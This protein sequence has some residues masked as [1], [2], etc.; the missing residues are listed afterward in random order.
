MT[1]TAQTDVDELKDIIEANWHHASH[2]K[3]NATLQVLERTRTENKITAKV[4]GNHGFILYP[5]KRKTKARGRL[6]LLHR[7]RRRLSSLLLS[8]AHVLNN[9][10]SF[11]AVREKVLPKIA[12][13][14]DISDYLRVR[15]STSCS[16]S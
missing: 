4:H 8:G 12:T 1:A 13:L 14:E 11:K 16:K 15:R 7:E 9:P 10:D 6:Q 3:F 5:S 2:P